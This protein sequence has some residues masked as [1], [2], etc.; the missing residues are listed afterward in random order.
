VWE[1]VAQAVVQARELAR[2]RVREQ[3]V[4]NVVE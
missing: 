1:Q 4:R 3:V 2:A